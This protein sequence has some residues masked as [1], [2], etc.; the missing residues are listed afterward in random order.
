[1]YK[2]NN[3][4][5]RAIIITIIGIGLMLSTL[6]MTPKQEAITAT[7]EPS[8]TVTL[9]FTSTATQAPTPTFTPSPSSTPTQ[10]PTD[11]AL[12]MIQTQNAEISQKLDNLKPNSTSKTNDAIESFVINLV[13][14]AFWDFVKWL[15]VVTGLAAA[16]SKFFRTQA[17]SAG[18]TPNRT[19]VNL[20]TFL[21]DAFKVVLWVVIATVLVWS[22]YYLGQSISQS[23]SK[24][25]LI[26]ISNQLGQI[27]NQLNSSSS[28]IPTVTSTNYI[29]TDS[30]SSDAHRDTGSNS[31]ANN[32]TSKILDKSIVIFAIFTFLFLGLIWIISSNQSRFYENVLPKMDLD[33]LGR[34]LLPAVFLVFILQLLPSLIS[35]VILPIMIPY[36]LFAFFDIVLLY[37]NNHL[38][39][40]VIRYYRPIIFLS[41]FGVWLRAFQV[42]QN[43]LNVFWESHGRA[44]MQIIIAY[45]LDPQQSPLSIFLPSNT[46]S[47]ALKFLDTFGWVLLPYLLALFYAGR[48]SRRIRKFAEERYIWKMTKA[49]GQKD[50]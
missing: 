43:Y 34:R 3:K 40:L 44:S 9:T 35:A 20:E 28:I 25:E 37:P 41:V 11:N 5:W 38:Q 2:K 18:V 46:L 24:T 16:I 33:V 13:S 48:P 15:F 42:F 21:G 49:E 23:S 45:L 30:P 39:N 50:E 12:V 47:Q 19:L 26:S 22:V 1:M 27:Q 32:D 10:T 29:T 7:P 17:V 36:I 31:D 4:I 8:D 14:G 6:A